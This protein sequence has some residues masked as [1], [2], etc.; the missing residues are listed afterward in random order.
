MFTRCPVDDA[1]GPVIQGCRGDFDF[2]MRFEGIFFSIL[3][4]C[5]FFSISILQLVAVIR[6]GARSHDASLLL[7]T[8]KS[9]RYSGSIS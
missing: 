6:R 3:P 4:N 9:V 5:V 8:A 7:L 2:T 1:L